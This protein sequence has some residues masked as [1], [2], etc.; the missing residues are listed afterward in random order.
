MIFN[1]IFIDIM[2]DIS[3]KPQ[4]ENIIS[5]HGQMSPKDKRINLML[6]SFNVNNIIWNRRNIILIYDNEDCYLI[7]TKKIKKIKKIKMVIYRRKR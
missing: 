4:L 7:T 5:K 6:S 3:S 2:V 1:Y